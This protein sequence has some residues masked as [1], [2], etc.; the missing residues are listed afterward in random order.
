MRWPRKKSM[1]K[2]KEALHAKT[3]RTE[4]RS[5]KTICED[6]NAVLKG[7]C[8]YFKHSKSNV[9]ATID[10]YTRGRLRS[11]LRKRSG[12]K[13]RGRGR[14]HQRWINA[15]FLARGLISLSQCRQA[16]VQSP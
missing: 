6:L 7:W 9:F 4:G 16:L 10:A 13:G 2:L 1:A 8:E 5:L 11:I 12:G 3:R 14:D 15:F